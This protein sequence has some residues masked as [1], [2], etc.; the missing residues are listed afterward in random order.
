MSCFS[1][2]ITSTIL[3]YISPSR[4]RELLVTLVG[5]LSRKQK[6]ASTPE[7][8]TSIPVCPILLDHMSTDYSSVDRSQIRLYAR[9][10]QHKNSLLPRVSAVP[11]FLPSV[12][13]V[14][15]GLERSLFV[16]CFKGETMLMK[17]M[18]NLVRSRGFIF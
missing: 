13:A 15:M 9:I 18:H 17:I 6:Q 4:I 11:I 8:L 7:S 3:S 12:A 2:P 1:R 10:L 16:T 14:S 5:L